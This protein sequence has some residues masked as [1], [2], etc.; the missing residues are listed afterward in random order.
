MA[1]P[2]GPPD[3]GNNGSTP[4]SRETGSPGIAR[5]FVSP[6]SKQMSWLLP[7]A[8][9]SIILAVFAARIRLPLE[10]EH[11]AL[12]LWGGWLLT[13]LIFFSSVEGIFHAYYA[14]MLAPA[15]GAV[16]G[17]GFGQLWRWQANRLWAGALLVIAAAITII[18]QIFTAFQYGA[19]SVW[20]YIPIIVLM[21][22][23]GLLLLP[24]LRRAGYVTILTA[25]LTIPLIWTALTVFDATPEVNLPTAFDASQQTRRRAAP[26][27]NERNPADQK[28]VAYLQANTQ[29]TE[30]LVAVPSSQVWF[31]AGVGNRT[32]CTVHG[33]LRR[34]RCGHQCGRVDRNGGKWRVALHLVRREEG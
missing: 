31:T 30:Y 7:F 29:D 12:V 34:R 20:V 18:F 23:A 14:I 11:K 24:F 26:E 28:L 1:S 19:T 2:D 32:P 4:I 15:L 8:L 3:G 6:L 5:F 16:V 22:G 21:A 9:I 17:G 33:R 10:P 25:L 13:C 27:L